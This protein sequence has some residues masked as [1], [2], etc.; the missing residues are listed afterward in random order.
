MKTTPAVRAKILSRLKILLLVAVLYYLVT[1]FTGC[2]FR[3]LL[4]ISCPGCG[5]TRAWLAC[6]HLDFALA[7]RLHP[8]FWMAP[9]FVLWILLEGCADLR[10]FHPWII[11]CA[12]VFLLT[13]LIRLLWFPDAVV[14]WDPEQG[15]FFRILAAL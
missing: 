10:R 2:P 5:V 12:G 11:L 4:G 7:F 1:R 3:F 14:A 6:L 15:L 9:V 13:Y 8:L